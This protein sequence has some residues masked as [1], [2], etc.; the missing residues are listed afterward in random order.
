MEQ[1]SAFDEL[2]YDSYAAATGYLGRARRNQSS[3]QCHSTLL[4]LVLRGKFHEAIR[5]V[6]KCELR[7]RGLLPSEM[8]SNKTGVMDKTVATVLKKK[9]TKNFPLFYAGGVQ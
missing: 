7:G 4:N 9:R 5:F 6:C 3:D 2:V 1:W 8:A